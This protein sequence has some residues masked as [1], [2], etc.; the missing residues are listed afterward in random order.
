M[1]VIG[2]DPSS[3]RIGLAH[4]DGTVESISPDRGVTGAQR[5]AQLRDRLTLAIR[6]RPPL[7]DLA[8]IEGYSLDPRRLSVMIVLGEVGGVVRLAM[9]DLTIGYVEVPP[10]S[11][12]LYATG[13]GKADKTAM[14]QAAV[15]L[16]APGHVNHDEADAWH[17]RRMGRGVYHQLESAT[18]KHEHDA[19][20]RCGAKWPAGPIAP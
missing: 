18:A 19:L 1:R 5:L 6:R 11:L 20:A 2:I 13:S 3:A 8:V 16:G 12:K 7:P 14:V 15:N 4:A 9:H 10:T 17:A